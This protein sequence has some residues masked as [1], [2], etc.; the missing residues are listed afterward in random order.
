MPDLQA[1]APDGGPPDEPGA[2]ASIVRR[3]LASRTAAIVSWALGLRVL[4]ACLAFL[5]NVVFP[6]HQPEQFT[7]FRQGH[8]FWDAFARY[9]SG[10]YYGIARDG[11]RFAEGGRS[12]LAFFP[13]YPL[14]MRALARPF[15]NRAQNYYVAGIVISWAAFVVAMV[16][17]DRVARLDLSR[18]A[19]TRAVLYASIFPF[20]FFYG[21]V[22]SESLFLMLTLAAV[23]GFRTRRWLIGGVGGAL[24]PATRVNGI[25]LLPALAWIGWEQTR[26]DGR[27]RRRAL[28]AVG[29][30]SAGLVIYSTFVYGL[31]GSFIEW[32][33]SI[34]R[35][36]Y[37]PGTDAGSIFAG[38][39]RALLTRPYTYL[40]QE[41][42]APYDVLNGGTGLL[43][44]L[45][46]PFVWRRLGVAYGI[47][48]V[49]NLALPVSAGQ[50]EGLGRYCA[51]LFPAF[52]W[53]ATFRAPGVQAALTAGSAMLYVLCLALFV[54]L[55]PIF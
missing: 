44:M 45:A 9:D 5:V 28:A 34:T 38:L 7:V 41:H 12:N 35:W 21:V 10:W 55:H 50:F 52:V 16:L 2:R 39:V 11:Y 22:Y 20:A 17:L 4:T 40:T 53:L 54:N 33:H 8:L 49:A 36:Q 15:G 14:L 30:A 27:E 31:T 37:V 48:M 32:Y 13:V 3:L 6:L 29:L 23:Y 24:A 1:A 46:I 25:M 18:R 42:A 26:G 47:L 43:F 51:V 19:A